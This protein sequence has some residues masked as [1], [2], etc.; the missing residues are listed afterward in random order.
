MA[1]ALGALIELHWALMAMEL[2]RAPTLL[3]ATF[4]EQTSLRSIRLLARFS[5]IT[6]RIIDERG[7]EI[8]RNA[9]DHV[10]HIVK[11]IVFS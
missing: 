4:L 9:A 11:T 3:T 5:E 10:V 8:S 1:E 7:W 2:Q 6:N